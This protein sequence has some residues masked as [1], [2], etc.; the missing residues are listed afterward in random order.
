M[1]YLLG[2]TKEENRKRDTNKMEECKVWDDAAILAALQQAVG[3]EK[4]AREVDE[5]VVDYL[6]AVIRGIVA[7]DANASAQTAVDKER[8]GAA[9]EEAT[10]PLLLANGLAKDD[11]QAAAICRALLAA[12]HLSPAPAGRVA[13]DELKVFFIIYIYYLY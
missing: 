4:L 5:A 10:T 2:P 6:V 7:E 12:L 3:K 13:D 8:A 9:V 1:K 11:D